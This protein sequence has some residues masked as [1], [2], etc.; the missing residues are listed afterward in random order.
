MNIGSKT[1]SHEKMAIHSENALQ[2]AQAIFNKGIIG[3][4]H[5][6]NEHS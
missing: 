4:L 6:A 5:Q 3:W 1:A 2:A